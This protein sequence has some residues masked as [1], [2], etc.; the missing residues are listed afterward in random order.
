MNPAITISDVSLRYSGNSEPAVDRVSLQVARGEL[1]ALLG[2]SGAGKTTL[3]RLI[4]GFE[5]PDQGSISVGSRVVASERVNVPVERRGIGFVFQHGA[6]FPHLDVRRNIAFGL[7][8]LGAAERRARVLEVARLAAID[9]LLDRHEH[10]L[11]GGE[12]QRAAL[13]RALARGNE[14]VLLDE[15]LSNVDR[16][17]RLE[18]GTQLRE[19][20]RAAGATAVMVT[21]DHQEALGLADRVAMLAGG[22]LLQVA[23]PE[24]IVRTPATPVVAS[25]L[26]SRASSPTRSLVGY[27]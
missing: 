22:R 26:A 19:I 9:H 5:M 24:E 11:S 2:P 7:G 16:P 10:E 3:L 8:Q 12:R 18:I 14:I 13:A 1:L 17:L 4:A 25:F 21:H 15:P 6:L 20:L 27:P 23:T